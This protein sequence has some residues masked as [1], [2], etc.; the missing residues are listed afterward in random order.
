MLQVAPTFKLLGNLWFQR[1]HKTVTLLEGP[2]VWPQGTWQ[3]I[4]AI[5]SDYETPTEPFRFGVVPGW[6]PGDVVNAW[7]R[8][9]EYRDCQRLIVVDGVVVWRVAGSA[10]GDE[11]FQKRLRQAMKERWGS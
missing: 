4:Q 5:R 3:D 6:A 10:L 2:G 7:Y 11:R 9:G 8:R 1:N